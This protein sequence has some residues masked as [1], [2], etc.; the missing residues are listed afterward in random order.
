[1]SSGSVS[2]L[3]S[4]SDSGSAWVSQGVLITTARCPN[5]TR[6]GGGDKQEEEEEEEV[7]EISRRR[8]RR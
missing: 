7:D 5:T 8:R 6:R 3:G 2:A 1:M 4:G